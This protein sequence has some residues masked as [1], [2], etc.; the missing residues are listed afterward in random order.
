M[1]E[2]KGEGENLISYPLARYHMVHTSMGDVYA[3]FAGQG[4]GESYLKIQSEFPSRFIGTDSS[5]R[6]VDG[7]SHII[8]NL[9]SFPP[10]IRGKF[11]RGVIQTFQN[12]LNP[13][14]QGD[15]LTFPP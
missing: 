12:P 6:I 13:P 3:C 9:S 14:C 8:G 2:D 1:G 10:L 5:F 7:F 11:E 15:L 4:E